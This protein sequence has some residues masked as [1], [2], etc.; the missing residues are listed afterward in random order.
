M[1]EYGEDR[2]ELGSRWLFVR[3]GLVWR[4]LAAEAVLGEGRGCWYMVW[5]ASCRTRRRRCRWSGVGWDAGAGGRLSMERWK[6]ACTDGSH[7][8]S[9]GRRAASQVKR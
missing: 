4:L 9:N 5:E 1:S 7:H 2:S 6:Q 3:V 8:E